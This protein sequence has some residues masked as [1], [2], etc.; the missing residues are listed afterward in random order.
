MTGQA[1]IIGD[2][3]AG[4]TGTYRF[5]ADLVPA[6]A[7]LAVAARE[8]GD[9]VVFVRTRFRANGTDVSARNRGVKAIFEA[10]GDYHEGSPGTELD[11]GLGLQPGDVL[12]TKRRTSALAGT[13]LDLVL[14]GAGI[15][16]VAIAGVATSA[17]VAATVYDAA[18][19]DYA[20]SVV[21][22]ACGD[23][24]P[25]VHEFLTGTVFPG[26]GVDVITVA[27]YAG[28]PGRLG[29]DGQDAAE[30]ADPAQGVHGLVVEGAQGR[31]IARGDRDRLV[32]QRALPVE[33]LRT[34]P[35]LDIREP[36][37]EEADTE[38]DPANSLGDPFVPALP[39]LPA[40]QR[41]P[42]AGPQDPE[43][44]GVGLGGLVG[45]LDRVGAEYRV[46][47][48]V[49]QAG[50]REV[51]DAEVRVAHAH[52]HGLLAR[53]R[54]RLGGEVDTDQSRPG[55]FCDL[56]SV[57]TPATGEVSERVPGGEA[58]FRGQFTE[59]LGRDHPG[60]RAGRE[61]QVAVLDLGDGRRG[62]LIGIPPVK[63]LSGSRHPPSLFG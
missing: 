23:P 51:A 29:G 40:G 31:V 58:E 21:A 62:R 18:D 12:V 25:G 54:E 63:V 50:G 30:Q 28:L 59:R 10:G 32:P 11:A 4:I 53:F 60:P 42:P 44:L 35:D 5:A 43:D 27:G 34:V 19:R 24:A 49:G 13:D 3:Q 56:K 48:G 46:D 2:L 38:V 6:A 39:G 20:V 7:A 9:L 36:R 61:A 17:M 52:S 16:S 26:R 22:D 33:P 55:P 14:R 47:A 8:R 37:P 1:V 57:V 41:G 15:G 45:E